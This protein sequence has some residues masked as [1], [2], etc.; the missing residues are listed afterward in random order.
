MREQQ[1]VPFYTMA[2][3]FVNKPGDLANP[4]HLR[5]LDSLVHELENLP[6]S[7]GPLSTNYFMRD[8]IAYEK[9]NKEEGEVAELEESMNANLTDKIRVSK[10]DAQFQ[11]SFNLDNLETFLDWPEYQFWRGFVRIHQEKYASYNTP[12]FYN[13]FRAIKVL[14][15]FISS[16]FLGTR[17][18]LTVSSSLPHFTAKNC[19]VGQ[20]E[21]ICW[22]NGA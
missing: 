11:P 22:I 8:F 3:V 1:I 15:L 20:K 9:E 17:L 16:L 2:T 19:D 21:A 6:E 5:R 10:D 13:N 18:Y 14:I 7:W 4:E 12:L